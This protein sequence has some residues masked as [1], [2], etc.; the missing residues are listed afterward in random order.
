VET[1]RKRAHYC[2]VARSEFNTSPI[3]DF[4]RRKNK[5][6]PGQPPGPHRSWISL[7]CLPIARSGET[8]V[9]VRQRSLGVPLLPVLAAKLRFRE[10]LS[11]THAVASGPTRSKSGKWRRPQCPGNQHALTRIS[12]FPWQFTLENRQLPPASPQSIVWQA[13]RVPTFSVNPLWGRMLQAAIE[14]HY[15]YVN[16]LWTMRLPCGRLRKIWQESFSVEF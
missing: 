10:S 12:D 3:G 14:K 15:A 11:A 13:L 2:Y 7:V 8:T 4:K 6:G 16:K 1:S 5:C 9:L